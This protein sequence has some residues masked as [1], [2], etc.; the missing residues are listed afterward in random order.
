MKVPK[1]QKT[2]KQPKQLSCVERFKIQEKLL[3]EG[4]DIRSIRNK[5]I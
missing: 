5:K 4:K 3:Q 1:K 2:V